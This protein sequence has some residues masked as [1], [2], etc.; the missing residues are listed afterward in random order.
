MAGPRRLLT[1]GAD[2]VPRAVDDPTDSPIA[3]VDADG[4]HL[5]LLT[6]STLEV[7]APQSL[8]LRAS[9][10]VENATGIQT[11]GGRLVVG[12]ADRV[13]TLA[14]DGTGFRF[15][16]AQFVDGGIARLEPVVINGRTALNVVGADGAA[17][18]WDSTRQ[19]LSNANVISGQQ[20]MLRIGSTVV[21]GTP[22]E[23]WLR[24]GSLGP[25]RPVPAG[26]PDYVS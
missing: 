7:R 15:G 24:I 16:P 8:R 19:E 5:Y 12:F 23:T 6:E 10:P 18:I 3:A 25:R 1:V 22:G 9:L 4:E 26:P 14:H 17:R 13:T 20:P 11:I 21:H 2:L